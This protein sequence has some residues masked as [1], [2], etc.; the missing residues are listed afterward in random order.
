MRR[1]A[2]GFHFFQLTA[3]PTRRRVNVLACGVAALALFAL[4]N[5][6][7]RTAGTAAAPGGQWDPAL[8][9]D[10]TNTLGVWQDDRAAGSIFGG[11]VTPG[12]AVL[13][14][15]GI[16]IALAPNDQRQADV[17]FDG[18]NYLV[19]WRDERSTG[20]MEI[21]AARV[22]TGGA[23][24][25]SGGIPVSTGGCCRHSPAV[26]S[27]SGTSLVAWVGP[28]STYTDIRGAR[29][30]PEGV[31]LDPISIQISDG[32][33]WEWNPAVAFDG[34][35][36]FV[37]W[38]DERSSPGDIYGTRVTPDGVALD[39]EGIRITTGAAAWFPTIAFD[40]TNYLVVWSNNQLG[41]IYATRVTPAGAVLDP[42]GIPISTATGPQTHP[43]VAFDGANYMVAWEDNRSG[44]VPRSTQRV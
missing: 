28:G 1:T 42:A 10:G 14:Q 8:A 43:S 17:A 39:P 22:T 31:V 4:A 6:P 27:G 21:Y 19:A 18:A 38:R 37:V 44:S 26:A 30:S 36:F 2:V 24:L 35:N 33:S 32:S 41:D 20:A 12:G 23:V 25:D 13:D 16:P 3:R 29:L 9:F 15:Q 7:A 5:S 34:T 11:R 40:G